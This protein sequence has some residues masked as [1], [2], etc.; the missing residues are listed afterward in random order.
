MHERFAALNKRGRVQQP[1]GYGNTHVQ[2]TVG[3]IVVEDLLDSE[4]RMEVSARV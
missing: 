3:R 4:L 1:T 2:G